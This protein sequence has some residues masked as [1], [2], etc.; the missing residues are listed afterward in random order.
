MRSKNCNAMLTNRR[1]ANHPTRAVGDRLCCI[2][3][4]KTVTPPHK[5][6]PT[7]LFSFERSLESG[8][9]TTQWASK[10]VQ[11]NTPGLVRDRIP[12]E[13]A[14][15]RF[16]VIAAETLAPPGHARTRKPTQAD[17]IADQCGWI[18]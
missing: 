4:W 11:Q 13:L 6:R 7:T 9:P 1:D 8:P 18:A 5:K 15:Q 17:S 12:S 3:R 16:V 10:P 2:Q 14:G